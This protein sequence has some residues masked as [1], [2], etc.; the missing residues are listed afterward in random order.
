MGSKKYKY[1][2]REVY[3]DVRID[4]K[5][6]SMPDLL[7]KLQR[8]REQIDH[9]AVDES[10]RL[11]DFVMTWLETYKK[12]TVSEDWYYNIESI[13]LK[14]IVPEIGNKPF[15]AIKVI[16]VQQ[17]LNSCAAYSS[18]YVDKIFRITM[19]IFKEAYKNRVTHQDYTDLLVKPRGSGTRT[20]R[21]ITD[22]ERSVLLQVLDGYIT[23]D[24]CHTNKIARS[25]HPHRG[26][27]FCKFMLYCGLRPSEAAALIWKDIDLDSG[28]LKINKSLSKKGTSKLPKSN[29]GFRSIPVPEIFL[30][31]LCNYKGSPFDHVCTINGHT[32][33]EARR[34]AMWDNIRRLMNIGMGCKVYRNELVP[35]F[36]LAD[37]FVLYNL[38]HTYC[39]DLEKAGVP[40]NIASR[41]MGHSDISLTAKIYT[42]ASAESIEIARSLIDSVGNPMGSTCSDY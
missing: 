12:E 11:R 14:K 34:R 15:S 3:H 17:F 13:A 4:I 35:P 42:H 27:L 23:E 10:V 28:I 25:P 2:H 37:D 31:E 7:A 21:S 9:G 6:D 24:F 16:H 5:S 29:A 33:T 41:L 36:P 8:K 1:R 40:I 26:N 19:Q 30:S 18:E 32:I 20:R 39:T 38:R 22:H